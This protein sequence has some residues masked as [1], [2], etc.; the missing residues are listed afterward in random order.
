MGDLIWSLSVFVA[1][2]VFIAALEQGKNF[3]VALRMAVGVLIIGI[4]AVFVLKI[5]GWTLGLLLS[6]LWVV[7]WVAIVYGLIVAAGKA[8]KGAG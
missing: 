2:A 5:L 3:G 4:A 1:L 6:L 7:V 8:I